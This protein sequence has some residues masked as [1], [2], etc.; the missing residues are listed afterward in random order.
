VEE[1]IRT[2]ISS[3][4]WYHTIDLGNGIVT[5]GLYDIRKY[6]RFYPLPATMK[7]LSALDIGTASGFFAF[8]MEKRGASPVV[9]T[10]LPS[11]DAH[12]FSPNV[13]KSIENDRYEAYLKNPF[14]CAHKHLKSSVKKIEINVYDLS[15][16][17]VGE[18]DVVFCG[19]MLLHVTD[20]IKAIMNIQKVTKR[21]AILS[22]QIQPTRSKKPLANFIGNP[23]KT[24]WWSM[25]PM[26]FV[27]MAKSAGFRHVELISMFDLI[28][29]DGVYEVPHAVIRAWNTDPP[30][31]MLQGGTVDA[32]MNRVERLIKRV[33]K[34]KG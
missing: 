30:A 12:D 8:E 26:C 17:T 23:E 31:E 5:K 16:Q 22:T 2:E 1:T 11:W 10:D 4:E 29:E 24:V 25:Y 34:K 32:M 15:K 6:L 27:N 13:K 7:G 20:P 28:S 18:F 3:L 14:A 21:Y 33:L 9:A 19:S